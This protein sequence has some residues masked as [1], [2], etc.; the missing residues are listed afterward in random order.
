[1]KVAEE[2]YNGEARIKVTLLDTGPVDH[3]EGSG[4]RGSMLACASAHTMSITVK[5]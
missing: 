5:A 2:T 1:M 3:A 4:V